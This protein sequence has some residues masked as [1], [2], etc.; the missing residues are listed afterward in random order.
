MIDRRARRGMMAAK[1][2]FDW[3]DLRHLA[4]SLER[5]WRRHEGM[6]GRLF[7]PL[8]H[9]RCFVTT[10]LLQPIH[11]ELTPLRLIELQYWGAM[12]A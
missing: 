1:K 9:L 6:C 5:A 10:A 7:L 4:Q 3:K 11:A 8:R 2:P 12:S